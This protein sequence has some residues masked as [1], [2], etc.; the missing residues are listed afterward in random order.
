MTTPK[1]D[2]FDIFTRRALFVSAGGAVAVAAIGARLAWLQAQDVF[3]H[4]YSKAAASNRFDLR[5]IVP[6]RGVI[7]DRFG[8]ALALAS[9][10]YRVLIVPEEADDL[11]DT[12]EA[13]GALLGMNPDVVARRIRDAENRRPFDEVLI[14]NGLE[15]PQFA[16]VNVRLPE[17]K[18]VRAAVGEQRYYPYKSAFAHPIGYVQ[19]PSQMEIDKVE[20]ADREAAGMPVKAQPG[21]KWDSP[22]ARYLRNP[23]VRIGKAGIEAALENQL[24]GQPGWLQVEVNATGRVVSEVT[25]EAKPTVQGASVV[26]TIDAELQRLAMERMADQSGAAVV[27]DIVTGEII[28][29]ASAPGFDPN[30]F[31]NGISV[32][33]FKQLNEWNHKPLFHKAVTGAYNPG[34]TMKPTSAMAIQEAGVD[35]K[36]RVNCPGYFFYGGRAFH[37]WQKTGHGS[38]DLRDAI[39]HSCDVYFYEMSLRA[40]QQRIADTARALG[41]GQKFD[42]S[43]PSVTSGV[44]PDQAWWARRRASEP[45]PAGMT[46]NTVIGQG[47]LVASPLQLCVMAARIAG[48]GRAVSPRLLREAPGFTPPPPPIQLPFA[49]DHFDHVIDGMIAVC[50]EAGGTATR[51]GDLRIVRDPVT[52][53]ALDAATAP[54]GYE[55]IRMGGKTGSAQVR[56]I[57]AAERASGVRMGSQ[58][59]WELRDNA[60]FICFAPAE[61]P[62]YACSVVIEHGEHGS[63]AAAPIA[64]DIMRAV[65]MRDPSKQPAMTL[66]RAT[67]LP[68][69]RSA[70]L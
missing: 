48:R 31:V 47:D 11:Q 36:A 64:S 51:A 16:A 68:V 43:V 57:S 49:P 61:A 20:A 22:H 30:D 17:L 8:D 18:G 21:E 41:L 63:S 3:D 60:L 23:D 62:R 44:V 38:V 9:K 1:R 40:G 14:K 69:R 28:V 5:P 29:M 32:A 55:R 37:C 59:A 65:L 42:V 33:D 15:W 4:E 58:I 39:K 7:F 70:A 52:G 45:W 2:L 13:L 50:N 24:Q 26:L 35:P 25:K 12:I 56:S 53:K 54:R 27:M 10:D 66:A 34:S 67:G 19:K 46:L 6:A